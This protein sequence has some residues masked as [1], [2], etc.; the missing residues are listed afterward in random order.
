[1][2]GY[3]Y[4]FNIDDVETILNEFFGGT[5]SSCGCSEKNPE[6]CKET[7]KETVSTNVVS[8]V[9]KNDSEGA[10][11]EV[12]L[13]GY[14]KSDI[15]VTVV[16]GYLVVDA[17]G[18]KGTKKIKRKLTECSDNEKISAKFEDGILTITVPTKPVIEVKIS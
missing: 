8:T 9:I 11:I 16:G 10:V 12:E 6:C 14:K 18:T 4:T 15:K 1:M 5:S 17:T 2:Y 13:P 7:V 3:K